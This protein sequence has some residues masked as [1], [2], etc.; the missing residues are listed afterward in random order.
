MALALL[1]V[2]TPSLRMASAIE[3]PPAGASAFVQTSGPNAG[4][5]I[6][7]FYTSVGGANDS[8]GH[9]IDIDVPC[10]WPSAST[11]TIALY[12]PE[13][14]TPDPSS[15]AAVDEVRTGADTTTF[16]LTAPDG[17]VIGPLTYTPAGGTNGLW[18]ELAT[19]T[20]GTSG[21][22]CGTYVLRT[23]TS[24]DDDNA[25]RLQVSHDPD[26]SVSPG[27]CSAL[28]GA[29]SALLDDGDETDDVDGLAAS[30]DEL[31]IGLERTS[32]QHAAASCQDFSFFVDGNVSPLTLNNFDMDNSTSITYTPPAGSSYAPSVAGS[33]SQNA[34]WNT[35]T[36]PAPSGPPPARVG[37]SLAIDADDVGWWT[38]T[39]CI[40]AGNQYIFE[41]MQGSTKYFD[42]P[43]T[44]V[45]TLG[46][47]DGVATTTVGATLTYTLSFANTSDGTATPGA[48]LAVTLTDPL[49][50]NA[51]LVSCTVNAPYTGAC[52]GTTTL[53][54][55]LD[56]PV[57]A[58]ASGTA[59]VVV[60]VTGDGGGSIVNPA[61][62]DYQDIAGNQYS[63]ELASDTDTITLPTATPTATVTAT[64]TATATATPTATV[65]A[66]ETATVMP[67]PTETATDVPTETPTP[68]ET[69]TAAPTETATPT[70]LPTATTTPLPSTTPTLVATPAPTPT[71]S[72][73]GNAIVDPLEECDD[74][75][76][77]DFDGC[78]ADC[79]SELI[80]GG[81][82][83]G[84]NFHMRDCYQEFRTV[85]V[86]ARDARD[87]LQPRLECTDDDP[88]CD[89]GAEPGDGACTFRVTLCLNVS[90]RR[91]MCD[92]SDVASVTFK[93]DA[94]T[95]GIREPIALALA[96]LGAI[97]LSECRN[98]N[99]RFRT[100]CSH[101]TECD[102]A[103]GSGDGDC[104]DMHMVFQPPLATPDACTDE[105]LIRVPLRAGRSGMRNG[106]ATVTLSFMPA[107]HP[108]GGQ[109]AADTDAL[110]LTCRPG[111]E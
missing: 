54:I 50:A 94:T 95:D 43:P 10:T 73:C 57:A 66:T 88:S 56:Q 96:E 36:P 111:S 22:G 59:T 81:G 2:L 64:A 45:M 110:R 99:R 82:A 65:T 13:S 37:D 17:V 80:A 14:Q 71:S 5:G 47:T 29:T 90:E 6:G 61:T 62:L 39:V 30:G 70:A 4:I 103:P 31:L 48:A 11:V 9:L 107:D 63:P 44:P 35:P 7:D 60:T 18:V 49:P 89:F 28:G 79:T 92:A 16:T 75:N 93:R 72:T 42:Q 15:P 8:A 100:V 51:S 91:F 24:N 76:V 105:V 77:D 19:F 74:G 55:T 83:C 3:I 101:D 106:R 102:T 1:S 69:A 21:W 67:T 25:W 78:A 86:P 85:P 104:R 40:S 68:T 27:T 23:T 12:D 46:L 34:L 97:P 20:P 38:A 26:C 87:R 108:V 53:T 33:V 84:S 109:R 98:R 41:A 52:T 58:G 32:F